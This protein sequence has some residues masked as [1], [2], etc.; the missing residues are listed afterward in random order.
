M[1]ILSFKIPFLRYNTNTM[2]GTS[3]VCLLALIQRGILI[4]YDML[5][6]LYIIRSHSI[7]YTLFSFS[8]QVEFR[9]IYSFSGA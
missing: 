4:Y 1:N 9:L 7:L 6:L 2:L 5:L 3:V 8:D